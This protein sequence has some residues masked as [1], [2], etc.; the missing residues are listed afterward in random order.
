LFFTSARLR[1]RVSTMS[2]DVHALKPL[3]GSFYAHLFENPKMDVP[4]NLYWG[5]EIDF[6]PLI[7]EDEEWSANILC[8]WIQWPI[9]HWQQL[10]D[11]TVET[12]SRP[13]GVESSLY[14]FSMHQPAKEFRL[15]LHHRQADRFDLRFNMVLDVQDLEGLSIRNVSV[16]G[17]VDAQFQGLIVVPVNISPKPKDAEQVLRAL[18]PFADLT[19]YEPPRFDKFRWLLAP[20]IHD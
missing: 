5:F 10:Q 8:E 19:A 6:E 12:S 11:C 16:A 9:R 7:V 4:R 1:L 18:E 3:T 17:S 2:S 15:S 20:R 14:V 13:D